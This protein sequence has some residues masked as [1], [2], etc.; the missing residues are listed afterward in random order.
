MK[1]PFENFAPY[2]SAENENEKQ[3]E[4]SDLHD[5]KVAEVEKGE[6]E[7]FLGEIKKNI[8]TALPL[9]EQLRGVIIEDNDTVA[10]VLRK[11]E[12]A[13]KTMDSGDPALELMRELA[14]PLQVLL[15]SHVLDAGVPAE[16]I[17][18]YL[19]ETKKTLEQAV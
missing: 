16:K 19:L 11:L 7:A 4:I 6:E 5:K 13:P 18:E 15:D 14:D 8:E 12:A 9:L 17:R 3:S 2:R 1:N 10:D